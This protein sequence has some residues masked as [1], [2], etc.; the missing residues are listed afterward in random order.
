MAVNAKRRQHDLG[1]YE[2]A[3][4][5]LPKNGADL[6]EEPLHLAIGLMGQLHEAGWNQSRAEA[7]FYD[8][9]GILEQIVAHL[10]LTGLS[11]KPSTRPF[12]HPGQAAEIYLGDQAIG[13]FGQIHPQVAGEYELTK[14]AFVLELDFMS[15][16]ALEREQFDFEALPKFPA[17]QRDLALVVSREISSDSIIARIKEIGGE[18]V[19]RAE[20]F[21]VY[22]GEQV[23]QG[24]RSLAFSIIYR[25]K[26]KTLSDVEVNK[27]QEE[28]LQ[29]L[30]AQYGAVVRG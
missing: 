8:L 14:K 4:V 22:Q 7:D 17:V 19:E 2:I 26:E 18:L 27:V 21:D 25:S 5:Y 11:L 1:I 23:P 3:R 16:L 9:K 29:K 13:Y 15:L 6:P 30:H 24:M 12:L 20:L 28:L 10:H